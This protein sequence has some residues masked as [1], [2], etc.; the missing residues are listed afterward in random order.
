[1]GSSYSPNLAY[2]SILNSNLET[3]VNHSCLNSFR[4]YYPKQMRPELPETQEDINF[5]FEH[6]V[7]VV[8]SVVRCL[9]DL[10]NHVQYLRNLGSMHCDVEV[11]QRLLQ[12]MGPVFCNTVRPL[13]LVQGRW[14]YQVCPQPNFHFFQEIQ[15]SIQTLVLIHQFTKKVFKYCLV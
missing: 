13:L 5:H 2:Q 8:D 14:S 10:S 6:L 15:N 4:Y 12:L 1:M 9:P 11:Q 3:E 7:A